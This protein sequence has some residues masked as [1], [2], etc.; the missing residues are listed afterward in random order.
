[1][2]I[3]K[4]GRGVPEMLLSLSRNS[5]SPEKKRREFSGSG[6]GG[7]IVM[8]P[9]ICRRCNCI[10]GSI[11]AKIASGV[12]PNLLDSPARFT[13]S[14][15]LG[16]SASSDAIRSISFAVCRESTPCNNSK[17]GRAWRIL[18][19]WRCP[20]KCQRQREGSRGIL[21][22]ASWTRLSP[23]RRSPCSTASSNASGGC[24]FDTATSL[25]ASVS[26]REAFCRAF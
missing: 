5:L 16:Y 7:G 14:R 26:G 18:F 3:D 1:M 15:T 21:A 20:M 6:A 2:P 12:N 9:S 17:R 24:V 22:F 10:S 4:E 8:S 25:G 11:S 19:F 23:K 13:S